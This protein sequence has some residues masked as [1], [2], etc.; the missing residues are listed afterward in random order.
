MKELSSDLAKDICIFLKKMYFGEIVKKL[1]LFQE[2]VNS[3]QKISIHADKYLCLPFKKISLSNFKK[4][5]NS[6]ISIYNL[7]VALSEIT[8][9][10]EFLKYS[11]IS[12]SQRGKHIF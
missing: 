10:K 1:D 12:F 3:I 6:G 9:S 2:N 11:Y 4:K 5:N 8:F 7:N